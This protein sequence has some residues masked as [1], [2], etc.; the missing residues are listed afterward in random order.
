MSLCRLEGSHD[1]MSGLIY[2]LLSTASRSERLGILTSVDFMDHVDRVITTLDQRLNGPNISSYWF[3]RWGPDHR[4]YT[5]SQY[6]IV[7]IEVQEDR[8]SS[9]EIQPSWFPTDFLGVA[10]LF[11][12]FYHATEVLRGRESDISANQID[13][14]M[15]CATYRFKRP[16]PVWLPE[17]YEPNKA[18][19]EF[20][21]QL[22]R[23]GARLRIRPQQKVW[24]LVLQWLVTEQPEGIGTRSQERD[25]NIGDED[26]VKVMETFLKCGVDPFP[27]IPLF[28][29]FGVKT[30]KTLF[31]ALFDLDTALVPLIY[32]VLKN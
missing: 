22:V 21:L 2:C 10:M 25:F 5:D 29:V 19:T 30:K 18:Q 32:S 27:K 9:A 23:L 6:I 4:S 11:R 17:L 13:R 8:S 15:L 16:G 1:Y 26:F 31:W 20:I 7:G 14:L 12:L 28:C 3:Q 24:R